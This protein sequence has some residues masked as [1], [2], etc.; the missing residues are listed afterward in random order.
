[1]AGVD[2]GASAPSAD[3]AQ[4]SASKR[5][6]VSLT[7]FDHPWVVV[8]GHAARVNLP[9]PS[10]ATSD[11]PRSHRTLRTLLWLHSSNYVTADRVRR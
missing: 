7:I 3:A 11:E 2:E 10:T 8:S 1:V 5:H 9:E 6:I 4:V